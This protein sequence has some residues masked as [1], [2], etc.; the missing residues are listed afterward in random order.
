MFYLLATAVDSGNV[1]GSWDLR[2]GGSNVHNHP[3][4]P[5]QNLPGHR[6]RDRLP[7][8]QELGDLLTSGVASRES[9][10]F[11]RNKA[12]SAGRPEPAITLRD[13][14]NF[15]YHSQRKKLTAEHPTPTSYAIHMLE[16]LD[17]HL[18][19]KTDRY[20]QV[21]HLLLVH[22]QSLEVFKRHAPD[23]LMMDCTYRTNKHN[24]LLLNI[25]GS[26]GSNQTLNL[27]V[28][29]MTGEA[30]INFDPVI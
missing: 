12:I 4:D 3:P 9:L 20:G 29:I 27:G 14:Y 17:Y 19:Y 23:V 28:A 25:I 15:R 10:S 6:A 1:E 24:Q 30:A 2:V 5:P 21:I 11:T 26:T 18:D 16:S 22:P 7:V 13:L 8:E